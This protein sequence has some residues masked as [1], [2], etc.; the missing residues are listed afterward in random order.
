LI[1]VV[2]FDADDTLLDFQTS[3]WSSLA[4]V[5][6]AVHALTP[7]AAALTIEDLDADW[8][9]NA[10]L[11]LRD[12]RREA[13]GR[14]LARVGVADDTIVEAINDEYYAQRTLTTCAYPD[15]VPV[16]RSLQR[17]Y[18]LGYATNGDSNPGRAGLAGL[19]AF[20]VYARVDGLPPKPSPQFF[21]RVVERSGVGANEIA[22][23][24]DNWAND[25]LASARA[26]MHAIWLNRAGALRPA[27]ADRAPAM[28]ITEITSLTELRPALAR[29]S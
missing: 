21:E 18:R 6:P 28:P 16:L 22:F 4:A 7:A 15:V 29:K 13:F 5:L 19:F 11:N 17:D 8:I 24:G 10:A 12:M 3:M 9:E 2:A 14:S 20:E 27:G 23:V 26:G 1:K 25:V